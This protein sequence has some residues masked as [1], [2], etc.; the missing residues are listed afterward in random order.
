MKNKFL[1]F[2]QIT[3]PKLK[4]QTFAVV[5][6]IGE[7]F[8]G[9]VKWFPRWRRYAFFPGDDSVFDAACLQEVTAFIDG[10]MQARGVWR[11]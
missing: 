7:H 10:L 4:T 9:Y 11:K 2:Q 6:K 1:D 5:S 3:N 8:L